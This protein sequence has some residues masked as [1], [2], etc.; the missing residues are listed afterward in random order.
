MAQGHRPGGS[1]REGDTFMIRIAVAQPMPFSAR[2]CSR[3][4]LASIEDERPRPAA[5]RPE[6][7][8]EH[9]GPPHREEGAERLKNAS[10]TKSGALRRS[11]RRYTSPN[12]PFLLPSYPVLAPEAGTLAVQH[13][14]PG[15]LPRGALLRNAVPAPDRGSVAAP[16][17][18]PE[19]LRS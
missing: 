16:P 5:K 1:A 9:F 7:I 19:K 2:R 3:L 8:K 12:S 4:D 11:T 18:A 10:Q 13:P 15:L 17:T 6:V 14:A